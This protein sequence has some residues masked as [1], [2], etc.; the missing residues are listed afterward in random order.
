MISELQ[1]QEI[2]KIIDQYSS[3]ITWYL[4][5]EGIIPDELV[6]QM[7]T[8]G[9]QGP[10]IGDAAMEEAFLYGLAK[11]VLGVDDP[12]KYSLDQLKD[13]LVKRPPL[14]VFEKKVVK[15]LGENAAT[16]CKGLGNRIEQATMKVV[17]SARKEA[18]MREVIR[19][20]MAKQKAER[21]TRSKMITELKHATQDFNRDWHRIVSTELHRAQTEGIAAGIKKNFKKPGK[22]LTVIVRPNDDACPTCKLAYLDKTGKPKLFELD[23]ISMVSNIDKKKVELIEEPG[24]PPLHPHCYHKD[25]EVYTECGWKLVKDVSVGEKCLSLDPSTFDLEWVEVVNAVSH[26]AESLIHFESMTFDLAVTPEHQM[27]YL[28]SWPWKQGRIVPKFADAKSLP[29]TAILYRSSEWVGEQPDF[30]KIGDHE[31]APKLF[32]KFMGWWLSEGSVV[33]RG[34]DRYQITISQSPGGII[35]PFVDISDMPVNLWMTKHAI[36]FYD[37][38]IGKYLLQFGHSHEKFVPEEIKAMTPDLIRVFLDTFR[39]GDGSTRKAKD[40][41]DGN[42]EDELLYTSSSKKMAD[43]IGELILKIGR[44]PSFYL[45]KTKGIITEHRN[46]SYVTNHDQWFVRE[47]RR[48]KSFSANIARSII[49]YGDMAYCIELAKNHTL[50]V[51]YNGKTTWCGNCRCQLVYFNPETMDLLPGGKV[52][53]KPKSKA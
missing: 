7:K 40:Y 4:T 2:L 29:S 5:G 12:K 53:F 39:N 51:R 21:A 50:W 43:D 46:G 26:V 32:C 24:L 13:M 30:V 3:G 36:G 48:Q 47:C 18:L 8:L 17:H 6:E 52:V 34:E 31:V 10:V 37:T 42:F 35:N 38:S 1:V 23:K 44:R 45:S 15:W 20:T 14:T 16:Y 22:V 9:L 33:K 28:K 11:V 41:K 49:E 25:T 19:D 27:F